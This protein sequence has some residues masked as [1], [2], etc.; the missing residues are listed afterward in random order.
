[1]RDFVQLLKRFWGYV[2]VG[3]NA[4][5]AAFPDPRKKKKDE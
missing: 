3:F 2:V 4:P 1:M 5:G